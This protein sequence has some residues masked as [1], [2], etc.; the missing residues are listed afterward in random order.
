MPPAYFKPL[1]GKPVFQ[2]NQFGFTFGGP[3]VKNRAF[4]FTDWEGFRERQKFPVFSSLPTVND[5]Q[6]NLPRGRAQSV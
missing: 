3:I 1:T 6:G 4:F 5:R 2:R